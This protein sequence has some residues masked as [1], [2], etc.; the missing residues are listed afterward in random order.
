MM[1]EGINMDTKERKVLVVDDSKNI[2]KLVTVI[3]SKENYRFSEA[4]NGIEALEK[5]QRER[6]DLV[7]LDIIIPGI[8]GIKVCEEIRKD[9]RTRDAAIIVLTSQSTYEARENAHQAGAD[10]FMMKPFEPAELRSAAK[11]L[12][13][14]RKAA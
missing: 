8:D 12:L 7:I 1:K 14:L 10:V 11:N 3:L 5:A 9:P 4:G 2:R 6:P 13:E